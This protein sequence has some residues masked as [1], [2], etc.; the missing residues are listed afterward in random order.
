MAPA[1]LPR[2]PYHRDPVASGSVRTCDA[3]CECCGE[4]RGILYAGVVYSREQAGSICPWCVFDGSA[5][6]RFRASFFDRELAR[7][8]AEG[9]EVLREAVAVPIE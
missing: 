2:F 7:R 4:S 1:A 3:A 5:A 8:E 9:H 6:A